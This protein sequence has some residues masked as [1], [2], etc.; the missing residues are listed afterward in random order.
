MKPVPV[1]IVTRNGLA[2]TKKTLASVIAQD[3]PV[4][5]LV[6]ENNSS[7]GTAQYLNAKR[8]TVIHAPEQ[9]A[10][11]KCWNVA[12]QCLW[13]A[14]WDR[15]IVLNNDLVLR[16]DSA[17]LM[18]AYDKPFVT[19]VSVDSEDQLGEPGDRTVEELR[20]VERPFPDFSAFM[21]SKSVTD[22]IGW[23][24]EAYYPAFCE[25]WDWHWRMEKAG[26]KAVCCGLPFLHFG[27]S[28]VKSAQP[29]ER[30]RIQRGAA[31]NRDYFFKKFGVRGG[32]PEY[33]A[34]FGHFAPV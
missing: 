34:H 8:L 24:D 22:K 18:D 5:I 31:Q 29:G 1:V 12:L 19:L 25:D 2:L 20:A 27:S 23:F 28:T 3:V 21:I 30:E 16:P 9:W 17:R 11:A 33:Y 32:T 7:D 6:V 4:E 26:I 10:L 15:A 14:G 13:K